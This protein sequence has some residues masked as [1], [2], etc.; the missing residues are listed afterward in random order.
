[1]EDETKTIDSI[2]EINELAVDL[3][4]A[5]SEMKAAEKDGLNPAWRNK[6]AT[7]DSCWNAIRGPLTKNNLALVQKTEILDNLVI[8][9]TI[10]LHKSGQFIE[11][12]YPIANIGEKPQAMGSALTYARRYALSAL[13]GLTADEDDDANTAQT[14]STTPRPVYKKHEPKFNGRQPQNAPLDQFIGAPIERQPGR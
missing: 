13:V 11:S 10:L 14:L 2:F 1:M 5:Q 3:A 8:L 12:V 6:Y 4:K 7:L 9:K